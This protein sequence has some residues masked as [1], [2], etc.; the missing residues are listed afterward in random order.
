MNPLALKLL[1]NQL[2][3]NGPKGALH[4]SRN[5]VRGKRVGESVSLGNVVSYQKLVVV[6]PLYFII[7]YVA[8][9]VNFRTKI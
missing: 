2:F 5:S 1:G 9:L 4:K 8:V 3:M 6:L 7:L